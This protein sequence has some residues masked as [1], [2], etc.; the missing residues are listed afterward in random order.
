MED[1]CYFWEDHIADI[2][3]EKLEIC[4]RENGCECE[5]CE[6]FWFEEGVH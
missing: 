2:D 5:D 6:W 1:F 4:Q 3:P